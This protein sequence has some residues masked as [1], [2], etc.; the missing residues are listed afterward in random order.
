MRIFNVSRAW[1][2]GL[3]LALG[4]GSVTEA[5]MSPSQSAKVLMSYATSGTI[6]SAGVNGTP[7]IS[8]NSVPS[9]QF[10]TPSSFSLGEFMVS[11]LPTGVSTSYTDTPFSIT[12]IVSSVDGQPVQ[13]T[14]Q[15]IV[16]RGTINGTVTGA[17]QSDLIVNFDTTPIPA[18]DINNYSNTLVNLDTSL[19]LVPSTTNGGRTTAQSLLVVQ[20]V[21]EPASIVIFG[22]GTAGLVWYRR[23]RQVV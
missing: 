5:G 17:S 10:T 22:L 6:D 2:T 8:F 7:V 12:Y 16:L 20:P 18:F 3:T 14:T 23:R 11:A 9:G 21:P 15:P 19:T 4:L 1:M 13:D